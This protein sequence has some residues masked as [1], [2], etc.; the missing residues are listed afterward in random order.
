MQQLREGFEQ[1]L[2]YLFGERVVINGLGPR[3]CNTTNCSFLGVDGE[4]IL[5]ALDLAGI[6]V[7]FGSACSSGGMERSRVLQNMGLSSARTRSAIR[8]SFG[9]DNRWEEVECV[10]TC[11]E[12]LLQKSSSGVL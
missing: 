7:S 10:L 4:S 6:A 2:A 9:R 1:R 3:T 11:L 8:F 5:M 12:K